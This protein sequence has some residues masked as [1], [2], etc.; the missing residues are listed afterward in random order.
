MKSKMQFLYIGQLR[1]QFAEINSKERDLVHDNE[2]TKTK[3]N[4][5]KQNKNKKKEQKQK[6]NKTKIQ[7]QKQKPVSECVILNSR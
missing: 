4:K 7:T 2:K 1:L 3:Q 6:Q 5:T